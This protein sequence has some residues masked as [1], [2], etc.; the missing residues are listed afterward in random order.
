[1]RVYAGSAEHFTLRKSDLDDSSCILVYIWDADSSP[2]YFSP[3]DEA[4]EFLGD[5]PLLTRSWIEQGYYKWSSTSQFPKERRGKFIEW[6]GDRWAWLIEKL[7]K[8]FES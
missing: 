3:S 2:E 1:M 8:D 4:L 6:F 5:R 7:E